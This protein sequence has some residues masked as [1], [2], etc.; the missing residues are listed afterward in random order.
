MEPA[1]AI[2]TLCEIF[3]VLI[4]TLMILHEDKFIIFEHNVYVM[5]RKFVI[6]KLRESEMKKRKKGAGK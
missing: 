1:M 4:I 5:F 3:A 2:R 6:R